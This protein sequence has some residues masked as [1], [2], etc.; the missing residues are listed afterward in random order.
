VVWNDVY[1]SLESLK[2]IVEMTGRVDEMNGLISSGASFDECLASLRSSVPSFTWYPQTEF[3]YMQNAS[4]WFFAAK[5]GHNNESHNHNDI[6]TF[7]LYK[8]SVPMFV[9]AGVGT[10][11]KQTFSSERYTI[12]SMQSDW[13]NLPLING[14]S[15]KDGADY[16]AS[17]VSVSE[18]KGKNVFKL[19]ISS[20]YPESSE[21]SSW[22]REYVLTDRMLTITDSYSLSARKAEDV[23]RFMVQGQVYLPGDSMEDGYV[24]KSGEVLVSNCGVVM[25]LA[26][27]AAMTPSVDVVS[28]DDPRLSNVW[29]DSLRRLSFTSVHDAPAKGKYVFR[30][31]EL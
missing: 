31:T 9:D 28:L 4:R 8:G 18:R 24:V 6:G 11:V 23:L 7:I 16:K 12:W 17:S 13:H 29:G 14:V 5:G 26:Y 3:C 19:D 21:C 1:R 25:R 22:V 20:A 10:Y 27:P 30:I 15:Q 2:Y